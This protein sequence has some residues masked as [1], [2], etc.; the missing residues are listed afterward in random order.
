MKKTW[1]TT[2]I[3]IALLVIAGVC[4]SCTYHK[5]NSKEVQITS[6]ESGI[7]LDATDEKT[8]EE[9]QTSTDNA[10][11]SSDNMSELYYVHICGAVASPGVY[12]AASYARWVDIITMAGG[13]TENAAGDYI[14]QAATIH[15]GERIYI[16][17]RE[18]LDELSREEYIKG[19]EGEEEAAGDT[20]V[21]INQADAS[22]LMTLP[23]VGQ[24]RANSILE[25]RKSNGNFRTIQDLMKVPGIK[26]GLFNKISSYITVD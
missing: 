11:A 10:V 15:D 26:E 6:F 3:V 7:D 19:A 20:L 14:N 21:N 9:T 17:T 24:S 16:P 25:Y 22:L 23:G 12:R 8:I 4:Y 1:I 13:L 2:G 18:E 5:D